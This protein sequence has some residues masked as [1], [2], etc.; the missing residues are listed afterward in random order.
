MARAGNGGVNCNWQCVSYSDK[1]PSNSVRCLASI[2]L[3]LYITNHDSLLLILYTHILWKWNKNKDN[4]LGL[5]KYF[6]LNGNIGREKL[7]LI[8]VMPCKITHK[9]E[10]LFF[11]AMKVTIEKIMHSY[12]FNQVPV[13]F[14]CI[15]LFWKSHTADQLLSLKNPNN[16]FKINI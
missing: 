2:L 11:R 10:V 6:F 8:F 12:N 5:L 3:R 1:T 9:S 4:I 7:A 15:Q 16:Q 14:F 13:C